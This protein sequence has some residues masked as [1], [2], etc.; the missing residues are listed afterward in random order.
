MAQTIKLKRSNTGGAV[1]TTSQLALGELAVNTKDGKFYLRKHVDGTNANDGILR[2]GP[3]QTIAY[4]DTTFPVISANK[5]SS[6]PYYNQGS[7]VG[8]RIDGLE[9]PT[10]I[11]VVGNTYKF[12][13]S[14]SSNS[15]HQL[16]FYLDA[17]KT[18]AYTTGVTLNGTAGSSGAYSEIVISES[19]PPILY[20]Q[21]VN[22]SYM[23]GAICVLS[24]AVAANAV[25][26]AQIAA[27]A[28][29]ANELASTG[30]SAGSYGSSSAIPV[31][32][33]DA[34][35]RVT[36]ATTA[37]ITG[38]GANSVGSAEI[39]ENSVGSSEIA[40]NSVGITQLNVT[41]GTSGQFLSTDGNGTLSFSSASGG[42][43]S[44]PD[45]FDLDSFTGN[46][47]STQFTLD[48]NVA[49][50]NNLIVFIDG[51]F[52]NQDSISL[53]NNVVTF[54]TAPPNGSDIRIYKISTNVVGLAPI[55]ENFT[56]NGSTT[57][58]TCTTTPNSETQFD[59]FID[60]VYQNKNTFSV[61]GAVVTFSTA[62]ASGAI[63]EVVQR[64]ISDLNGIKGQKGDTGTTGDK[65][66]K[67]EV[68][69]QG[70]TGPTGATGPQGT[71]GATGPQGDKGQKGEIGVTG[72]AGP[73]GVKGEPST[74]VGPTGPTGPQ[75][76][77]GQKGDTGTSGGTGGTGGTGPKGE[78]GEPGATGA[79]GPQGT[80]GTSGATGPQ[81]AKGQKGEVGAQGPTGSTGSTGPQ[82][83]KGEPL[84]GV[85]IEARG[86]GANNNDTR[87]VTDN[88]SSNRI[89]G[90][91]RGL[92]LALYNS[93]GVFQSSASYDTYG[94]TAASDNLATAING[95]S[96]YDIG[97]LASYDA[98][99]GGITANL[100][101]AADS[102]GLYKLANFTTGGSRRPY[103][104]IFQ[105]TGNAAGGKR[106]YESTTSS[107]STDL[108]AHVYA[109]INNNTFHS[110]GP[111]MP[112]ALSN[113]Y[114]DV[115]FQ[116]DVDGKLSTGGGVDVIDS[117]G[118]WVGNAINAN[119]LDSLDSADFLR[120]NATDYFGST[121]SNQ[122]ITF[123][124]NSAQYIASGGS[125]TRF[126]IEV[127]A[128]T[129]NGGDAAI[130]FHID[131]DYAG[132]FGLASDVNDLCWGGWSV[133]SATKHRIFHQGNVGSLTVAAGTLQSTEVILATQGIDL[134]RNGR[135]DTG[136]SWYSPSY[137]A[138]QTYMASVGAS[139]CG[140][141]GNVT[142]PGSAHGVSAWA[143]RSYIENASGY[144]WTWESGTATQ[145]TGTVVM[146]LNSGS[147]NLSVSGT[148]TANSDV[149]IKKNIITIENALDKVLNL[150]GVTFQRTDTEDDSVK[151]GVIAQEVEKIVPEV[152]QLGDPEDPDSIRSVSYGN[153]VGLLIEA[154]KE[155]Q[156]E[157]NELKKMA[158]PKCGIE[159]FEGYAELVERLEKLENGN[160]D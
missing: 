46:G 78:K 142:A 117:S 76:T 149:R 151:M 59:I 71:A 145:T 91:G 73:K 19:T 144:G 69:A 84:E 113:Y 57:T 39:A 155:Q 150:R 90:S 11:F 157:I 152:V 100:R 99:E 130:S 55:I 82:G 9:S 103:A 122:T 120:S 47:S 35:G 53:S 153:M 137:T 134:N 141:N 123:R 38:L 3:D 29:G 105:K 20:Y 159:T 4:G 116:I 87:F 94:S 45:A 22:H 147:G 62:P 67:G 6:H 158:H 83:Q 129:P 80:A 40:Q 156:K 102:V 104:A 43:G 13:Q 30:V 51:T 143:L 124:C 111:D 135:A 128:P 31:I 110:L 26:S 79:T 77:K 5:T 126:P 56:G 7:G 109:V 52:Q 27:G 114:G 88:N 97:V 127:Y 65:G 17:A 125:N 42:G 118:N 107:G 132:Y 25:G 68:G 89:S 75:G 70:A 92:A 148:V 23:G 98:I 2:F 12:D 54:D 121:S 81:G 21:C 108:R 34:D 93:S 1:P 10:Y 140:P 72:A 58:F 160:N 74:V 33:V 36:S 8:Y 86:T 112:T 66:Q 18:T 28:V 24:N 95:M 146:G 96:Q 48:T 63:I 44:N 136:L 115:A 15:S 64:Q 14:D 119:T 41:D 106:A 133:G 101:T 138:W 85:I 139:G 131:S 60:G 16:R 37:A 49:S 50:E 32:T 154:I 61:S